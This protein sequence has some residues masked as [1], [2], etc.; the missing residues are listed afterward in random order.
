MTVTKTAKCLDI[1]LDTPV[2]F[3]GCPKLRGPTANSLTRK[4][5]HDWTR[6]LV[7]VQSL[8]STKNI[9]SLTAIDFKITGKNTLFRFPYVYPRIGH[10]FSHVQFNLLT[11]PLRYVILSL[12]KNYLLGLGLLCYLVGVFSNSDERAIMLF[13]GLAGISLYFRFFRLYYKTRPA[14][15]R[16]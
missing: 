11:N 12:M 15:R 14:G 5:L 8:I 6:F 10:D 3:I 4:D 9:L 2:F 1:K 7:N 13:I 16:F